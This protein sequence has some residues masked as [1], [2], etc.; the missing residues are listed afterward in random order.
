MHLI[1]YQ[2]REYEYLF[3][4]CKDIN[5][6]NFYNLIVKIYG[7]Y[8]IYYNYKNLPKN[9]IKVLDKKQIIFMDDNLQ[10]IFC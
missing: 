7:V 6:D 5:D 10:R 8:G 2:N 3:Y 9:L 1:T 4:I